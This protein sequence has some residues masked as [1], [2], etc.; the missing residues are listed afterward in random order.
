MK[1]LVI[2]DETEALYATKQFLERRGYQVDTASS[3][4][5]GISKLRQNPDQYGVIVLDYRMEGKNGAQTA[6]ECLAIKKDLYI[7]ILSADT[8]QA[9]AVSTWRAGAVTFIEKSQGNDVFL[10]TLEHWVNKYQQEHVTLSRASEQSDNERLIRSIG[11]IGA[12]E[13]LAAIAQQ[14]LT[15]QSKESDATVLIRGESGT[16]KELIAKAIHKMSAQKDKPFVAI[17]C[18]A[19][20]RELASSEFFGHEKGAF[21]NAYQKTAG[22][23]QRANGGTIFLDEVAEMN[24]ELQVMLLRVLQERVITPLG[25]HAEIPINARVIAATNMDLKAAIAAGRFREDLYYR[26]KVAEIYV[27]PLRERPED[28]VLLVQRFTDQFNQKYKSKKTFLMQT[29]KL[30]QTYSWPGNVRELE[31]EIHHLVVFTTGENITPKDLD[32]RFHKKAEIPS[33]LQDELDQITKQRM[34][35]ALAKTKSKRAA[36]KLLG[37]P[38][39]SFRCLMKKFGIS[40]DNDTKGAA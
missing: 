31:N 27:P 17:N 15:Y 37:I 24:P 35:D 32:D 30:M 16:G 33:K 8:S 7:L 5:E 1:L 2:D 25:S 10:K 40:A 13:A 18:G 34:E 14:V 11:L 9:A 3:G 19:I 38:W 36:A 39:T 28:F 6:E 20:A 22:K 21:T 26:L 23:F 12:S 29:V 4:G